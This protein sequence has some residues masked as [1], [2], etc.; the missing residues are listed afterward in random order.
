M[1]HID[2]DSDPDLEPVRIRERRLEAPRPKWQS[3]S[4]RA[5]A[6]EL[7][8]PETPE[9]AGFSPSLNARKA[10]RLWLTQELGP[11]HQRKVIADVV[12]RVRAGKEATVYVCSTP[13]GAAHER[14]AA[15]LYH[16]SSRRTANNKQLYQLGRDVLD[17]D[18]RPVA[19]RDWRMH[20]AI[21]KSSG[22]GRA[23]SQASWLQHEFAR[24]EQMHRAGADV[25]ARRR[26]WPTWRSMPA[27]R[28]H[29]SSAS[30][31][32]SSC[33]CRSAGC[34]V[35]CRLTTCSTSAASPR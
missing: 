5:Q 7:V 27:K 13:P 33:S 10:E 31:G 2:F 32:T 8:A 25:P 16:A 1:K 4:E 24:L 26:S 9:A 3:K 23:A 20:K 12:E 21:A 28:G 11:F 17:S 30:C 19:A 22:A 18:G 34:T 14:I 35:I 15:K 29:C 6:E